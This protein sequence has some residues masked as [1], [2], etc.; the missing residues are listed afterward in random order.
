MNKF[1][2][3]LGAAWDFTKEHGVTILRGVAVLF[4]G[5]KV[6]RVANQSADVLDK[7]IKGTDKN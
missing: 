1:K 5:R 6:G 7:V 2:Q 4:V 3:Y